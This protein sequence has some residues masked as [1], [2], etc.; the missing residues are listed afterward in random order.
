MKSFFTCLA[1]A[2]SLA[3]LAFAAPAIDNALVKRLGPTDEPAALARMDTLFS[4]ITKFTAVISMS[5]S[6]H[7]Y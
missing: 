3:S 7:L 1:F 2:S 5:I 4:D 6:S